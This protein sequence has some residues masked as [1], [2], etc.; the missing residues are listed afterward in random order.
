VNNTEARRALSGG[1]GL[2]GSGRVG[3]FGSA[4]ELLE[5]ETKTEVMV[6]ILGIQGFVN[7]FFHMGRIG[8]SM[9]AKDPSSGRDLG[10]LEGAEVDSGTNAIE[11]GLAVG[12]KEVEVRVKTQ[13][14]RDKQR[15]VTIPGKSE[16]IEVRAK[17]RKGGAQGGA[18]LQHY[19]FD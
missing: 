12:D 16:A 1:G 9:G 10:F 2:F 8:V 3:L 18:E 7:E 11:L 14:D 5:S 4:P 13:Q 15:R 19:R 6:R 17:L